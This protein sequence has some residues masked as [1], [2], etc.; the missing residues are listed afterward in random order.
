MRATG[1]CVCVWLTLWGTALRW[2]TCANATVPV[3]LASAGW[4]RPGRLAEQVADHYLA[5]RLGAAEGA[6]TE[7]RPEAE[8]ANTPATRSWTAEQQSAVA[9]EFYSHELDATYR[10]APVEDGMALSIEQEAALQVSL[11]A[12]DTLEFRLGE[13]ALGGTRKATLSLDRDRTGQVTGFRLS[14]SSEHGLV[15]ERR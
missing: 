11:L 6:D 13:E 4:A 9:G 1:A 5:D 10:F 3:Q 12:D 14:A 15:F 7:R 8:G 2:N